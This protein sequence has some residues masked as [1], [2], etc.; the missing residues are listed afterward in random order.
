MVLKWSMQAAKGGEQTIVLCSC[1][2]S[3]PQQWP[4]WQ[5]LAKI[6][7]MVPIPWKSPK[8]LQLYLHQEGDHA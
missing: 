6:T 5:D 2:T 4:A 1:G 7:V 3:E 8:D